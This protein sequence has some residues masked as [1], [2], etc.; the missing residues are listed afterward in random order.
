MQTKVLFYYSIYIDTNIK[1]TLLNFYQ[2]TKNFQY[3]LNKLR[4]LEVQILI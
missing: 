4:Q 1:D 2:V 3:N